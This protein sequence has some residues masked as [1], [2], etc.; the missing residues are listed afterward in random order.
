M[1]EIGRR[2]KEYF[3]EEKEE[4]AEINYQLIEDIR[5][6]ED[7]ESTG[8]TFHTDTI[9]VARAWGG[10]AGIAIFDSAS[11]AA[12]GCSRPPSTVAALSGISDPYQATG[13]VLVRGFLSDI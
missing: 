9:S 3:P 5:P 2:T 11:A 6:G 13:A 1:A 12:R 10:C 4:S 7:E 8:A